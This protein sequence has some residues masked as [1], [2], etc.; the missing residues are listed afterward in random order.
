MLPDGDVDD[1]LEKLTTRI[2][3]Q[4]ERDTTPALG[5]LDRVQHSIEEVASDA[6]DEAVKVRLENGREHIFSFLETL[7][8]RGMKQHG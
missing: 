1:R 5:T 4:A 3:S 7:D 2:E 8:D 6:D